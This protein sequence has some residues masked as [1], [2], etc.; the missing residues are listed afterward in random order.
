MDIYSDVMSDKELEAALEELA[1]Y[2]DVDV[3]HSL[4]QLM[5]ENQ[6]S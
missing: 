6:V 2:N 5:N 4:A 1:V 3:T